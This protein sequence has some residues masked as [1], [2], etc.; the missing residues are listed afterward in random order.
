MEVLVMEETVISCITQIIT[1]I[2]TVGVTI[3][4]AYRTYISEKNKVDK[5]LKRIQSI[6]CNSSL[7]LFNA[8]I[9]N[10]IIFC[11]P[12]EI[13][14][15]LSDLIICLEK[16]KI[17]EQYLSELTETDLPDTFIK[18]FRFYRLKIAF[19][20]IYIEQRLN[21]TS[22]EFVPSSL[23]DDLETLELIT[24]IKKFIS[25]YYTEKPSEN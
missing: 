8:Y 9:A 22:S 12:K 20:R 11:S 3:L 13:D 7:E 4:I 16:M 2:I 17:T 1:T 25:S 23:F 10:L 15:K 19:Q 5:E 21:D 6:N 24:S 14:L 18:D